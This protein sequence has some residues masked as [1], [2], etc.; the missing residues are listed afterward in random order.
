MF[1]IYVYTDSEFIIPNVEIIFFFFFRNG[2]KFSR[3]V[4]IEINEIANRKR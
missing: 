2:V 1:F 3:S 4:R